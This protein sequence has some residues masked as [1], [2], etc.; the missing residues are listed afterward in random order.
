MY[1][2]TNFKCLLKLAQ[3]N[4]FF[5]SKLLNGILSKSTRV[6]NPPDQNPSAFKIHPIKINPSQNPPE[7]KSTRLKVKPS[8]T[9]HLA[10]FTSFLIKYLLN[11][12]H[13]N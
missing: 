2:E 10:L 5:K 13:K 1:F 11:E 4:I 12:S 3:P 8:R 9:K 7:L 6:Q